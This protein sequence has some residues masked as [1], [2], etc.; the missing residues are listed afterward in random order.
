MGSA[1][2]V[3]LTE[4]SKGAYSVLVGKFNRKRLLERPRIEGKYNIKMEF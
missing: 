1:E 3:A 4:D 2:Q